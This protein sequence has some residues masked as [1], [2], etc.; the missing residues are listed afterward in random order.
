MLLGL[1]GWGLSAGPALAQDPDEPAP[2]HQIEIFL[3]AE[4]LVPEVPLDEFP[5]ARRLLDGAPLE[6]DEADGP[7]LDASALKAFVDGVVTTA[8]ADHRIP[9]VVVAVVHQGE[10]VLLR[11]YGYAHEPERRAVDPEASLFRVASITKIF[12][13][14]ALLQLVDEGRVDL[15]AEFTR[16]L[17]DIAFDLPYGIPR[18]RDLLTHTAGFEDAYLGHFWA[19]DAESEHSLRD[20]VARFQPAQVRAPGTALVYSNFGTSVIG[21]IVETVSG[22][23]YAEFVETRILMPLGMGQSRMRDWP[24]EARPDQLSTADYEQLSR[25][26]VW[27]A[28]RFSPPN[29]AWMHGGMMPAGGLLSTGEDVSRFMLAQLADGGGIL[30]PEG[31]RLLT[32]PSIANHPGVAAN[33]LGYWINEVW[34]YSTLEHGGSIFGFLSNL[35]LVPELELGVFVSTNAPT[36]HRLSSQLPQRIVRQFFAADRVMPRPDAQAD[37]SEFA[38]AF[39][40][41]RRG[42]RTV[43][44]L[45]A[46][47]S[48]DLQIGA[49]DQG[50][51][52]LSSGGQTQRFVPLGEDRFLDPDLSEH[53]AFSRDDRGRVFKL[54][55]AYGH[56]NFVRLARW[57]TVQ[58]VHH[59]LIALAVLAAWWLLALAFTRRARRR[60]TL[61]GLVARYA[62]FGL[63]LAW[64]A[65]VWLL[66]QDM[67][68]APSPTAIQ[69]A[70]FPTAQGQQWI[71]AS[72]IGSALTAVMLILLVPV[73]RGGQWGLGRRLLASALSLSSVL[74]VFL[75]AYW[76]VLGAPVLGA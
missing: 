21:L 75:L 27:S 30:S 7:G 59:V 32:S 39:R 37:L 5:V 53:I 73:W 76:N 64:A 10:T 52:T 72:W 38:G 65:F 40:G 57:Q 41:Q 42:H 51:L 70:H 34:A 24:G 45:L 17:P 13:A 48:G 44:K 25:S 66:N 20:Y 12:N 69:F 67:L 61:S 15:D 63:L 26:H 22:M 54:H 58:F 18:V 19:V 33:A 36:G 3:S 11:G 1:Y 60:E 35:V 71:V 16:Y 29:W 43:D 68:Q 50:F 9:G 47:R 14:I 6:A 31:M 46:F 49:N 62:S 2:E 74:F 28:G 8:M 23:P 55:G 56:N 4:E